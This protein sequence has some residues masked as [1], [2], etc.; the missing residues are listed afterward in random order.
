M[1][2][3]APAALAFLAALLGASASGAASAETLVEALAAAYQ[4]NPQINAARAETR[5][6]DENL[7]IAKAGNR[8][9]IAAFGDVTGEVTER[10][11]SGRQIPAAARTDGTVGLRF[12]Q[13]L[14]RGFRTRNAVKEADANIL[15]SREDLEDT[16][17]TVLLDAAEAYMDVVRDSAILSVRQQTIGFLEEQVRAA[18]ARFE[19][20]ETTRTDV[21]QTRARLSAAVADLSAAQ[22]QLRLSQAVYRQVVGREPGRLAGGFPFSD[23]M[24]ASLAAALEL[25]QTRHPAIR[26]AIY[27]ADAA[28][29]KAKQIEGEVLPTVSLEGSAQS[30]F[31]IGNIDRSNVATITGRVTIPLYQG[32]AV[33]ARVRQAKETLGLRKIEIDV[34]RDQVRASIASAWAELDSMKASIIAASAQVE[35]ANIVLAGVQEEQAVGQ[36]TT[37]DVLNAQEELLEAR[38]QLIEAQRNRVVAAVTLLSATGRLRPRELG[39]A[40]AEYRPEEHYE[41][42]KD[43]WYGLRTPDGR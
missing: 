23:R 39:I 30:T 13:N 17:Q 38:V 10:E 32:G 34:A 3:V 2:K 31:G 40:V 11:R 9:S 12:Q 15:A 35:A 20:G 42:V 21:A 16:V 36:R 19:V 6:T 18:Q 29:F 4:N 24:P 5:V 25:G 14:F 27:R 41:A 33:A 26:A 22:A 8:P 28:A 7:P 37:L 1:S 43:K